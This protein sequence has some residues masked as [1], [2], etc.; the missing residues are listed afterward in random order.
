MDHDAALTTAL[1]PAGATTA[2][3]VEWS[4]TD[5]D[6][7]VTATLHDDLGP[8]RIT[9]RTIVRT[10]ERL[11]DEGFAHGVA[12][13]A[14]TLAASAA[15]AFLAAR[16]PPIESEDQ[17]PAA[18]AAARAVDVE[19]DA[20]GVRLPDQDVWP[21]RA[22]EVDGVRYALRVHAFPD[23]VAGFGDLGSEVFTVAADRLPEDLVLLRRPVRGRV[24]LD[25]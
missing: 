24:L 7:G 10:G 25:G 17:R 15:R 16:L 6:T 3:V 20:L 22:V 14:L 8:V 21:I 23:G 13:D 18:L 2:E 12:T 4:T 1:V 9:V 11:T 19:A 5:P